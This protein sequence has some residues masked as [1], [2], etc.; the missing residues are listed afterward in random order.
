MTEYSKSKK[1]LKLPHYIGGK[2]GF[3]EFLK[4]NLRYPA[5][6]LKA[7]VEGIVLVEYEVDDNGFVHNPKIIKGIGYGCDEEAIRLVSMMKYEKVKN[8]GLRVKSSAKTKIN[9]KLPKKNSISYTVKSSK[10]TEN[11]STK[12]ELPKKPQ[13]FTYTIKF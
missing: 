13:T 10:K 5:E 8:R 7:G 11:K 2:K 3:G 9:F 12:P 1:F 6:A 4:A